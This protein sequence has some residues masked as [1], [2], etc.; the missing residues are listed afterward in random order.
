MTLTFAG[1][2]RVTSSERK[3]K[4]QNKVGL[5]CYLAN[6]F[7]RLFTVAV[8]AVAVVADFATIWGVC[9]FQ[10]S[11]MVRCTLFLQDGELQNY[12]SNLGKTI[13]FRLI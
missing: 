4:T 13:V 6:W 7:W 11:K 3:L 8:A 10:R 1:L 9:P 5:L 2:K 12:G